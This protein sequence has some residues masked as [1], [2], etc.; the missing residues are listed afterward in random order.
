MAHDNFLLVENDLETTDSLASLTSPD[1][2]P[3]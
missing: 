3:C 1:L 2:G